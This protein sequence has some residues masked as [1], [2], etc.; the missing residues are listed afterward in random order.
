MHALII[1]SWEYLVFTCSPNLTHHNHVQYSFMTPAELLS[2]KNCTLSLSF[3]LYSTSFYPPH[4]FQTYFGLRSNYPRVHC[5][6]QRHLLPSCVL[7][8]LLVLMEVNYMHITQRAVLE[9]KTKWLGK[10]GF[11]VDIRVVIKKKKTPTT[12]NWMEKYNNFSI[13]FSPSFTIHR[14]YPTV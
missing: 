9:E 5:V 12:E 14:K 13:Y 10:T 1:H 6:L 11:T 2:C 7:T 3:P 4:Y 8:D